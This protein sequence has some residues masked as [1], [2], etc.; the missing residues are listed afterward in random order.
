MTRSCVKRTGGVGMSRRPG[1][2]GSLGRGEQTG[3]AVG[4]GWPYGRRGGVQGTQPRREKPQGAPDESPCPPA[5][6]QQ[7]G[8]VGHRLARREAH[9]L[10]SQYPRTEPSGG[11]T[12]GL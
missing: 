8:N 3:L 4:K 1:Q 2:E 6:L 12:E 7:L 5:C 11:L 10:H 9:L